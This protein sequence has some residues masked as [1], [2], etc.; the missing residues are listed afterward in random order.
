VLLAVTAVGAALRFVVP[1]GIWLDEAISVHQANLSLHD[2]FENLQ[3]GDRHPPLHHLVLWLTVKVFGDSELAVRLPSLVAGTLVIPALFLLG[4]EL[5][6]RRTGLV[7]AAFG[8]AS[9]L[10]IWYAQEARMYAFV[11]LF[12]LLALWTQLRVIR[13]PTMGAWAAYILATAALLWSHY[14]G[15]LL[16]GVQQLIFIGVILH[17]RR[18]GDPIRPLALGFAYSLAVLV[19]QLVPLLTFAQKQFDSTAGA[20]GSPAGTYEGLSFYAVVSNIAWALWG[21][22]PDGTTELLAAGWPLLLLL[23]LLL[24]GRGGSRQTIILAVAAFSP[25]LILIGVGFYDRELFE[26]RYFLVAV[27]LLFLLMARLVTGW[28]RGPGARLAVAGVV[29]ATLLLGLW[30]QQTNDDNP[31]LYDFRGALEEIEKDAGPRSLL[32]Y[33]PPDMKYV[34]E[35]YAPQLRSRP[36]R[37]GPPARRDG[38]PLFVLASFQDNQQFFDR[39]NKIVGQIDFRRE[40]VRRFEKPQAK[41]WEF[42]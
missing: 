7:A 10:L 33:E 25:I 1:R 6:D 9:P 18:A 42:R 8:A 28:I 41:V 16:I 20:A 35:Y 36:L 23:S 15:L 29:V 12:G 39:T 11:T 4:R 27:P 26:V 30:D 14:F 5:Y 22:H 19:M 2:M 17:K 40:L 34:L 13:K 38:S 37:D 3:Y 24:L 21:Y 32:I 31:R